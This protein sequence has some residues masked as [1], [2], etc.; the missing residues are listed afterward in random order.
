M[1]EFPTFIPD[2]FLQLLHSR[3]IT[4]YHHNIPHLQQH[5]SSKMF[6]R[7]DSEIAEHD[8]YL[9]IL[10]PQLFSINTFFNH[11]KFAPHKFSDKIFQPMCLVSNFFTTALFFII[12]IN[13]SSLKTYKCT[14]HTSLYLILGILSKGQQNCSN[15]SRF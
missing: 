14:L 1:K 11:I 13:I 5:F 3:I 12:E 2:V 15:L 9:N 6:F 4:V 10:S 7:V 8:F